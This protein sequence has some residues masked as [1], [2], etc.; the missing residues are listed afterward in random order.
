MAAS[1]AT[2]SFCHSFRLFNLLI[3]KSDALMAENSEEAELESFSSLFQDRLCRT[4]V[5]GATGRNV[6][7]NSPMGR[8]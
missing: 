5:Q 4:A 8:I 1:G 7:E 6:E 2:A 3:L